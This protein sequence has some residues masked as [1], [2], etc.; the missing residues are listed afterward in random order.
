MDNPFEQPAPTDVLEK[1][2]AFARDLA[3]GAATGLWH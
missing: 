2:R 3:Y 1:V